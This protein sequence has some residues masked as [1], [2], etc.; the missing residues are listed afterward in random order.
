[1]KRSKRIVPAGRALRCRGGR[2]K[3][4]SRRTS[5]RK[6]TWDPSTCARLK[7]WSSRRRRTLPRT[8]VATLQV[9]RLCFMH[10]LAS[11]KRAIARRLHVRVSAPLLPSM[12][13]RNDPPAPVHR[14][15]MRTRVAR[16]ATN[17]P[18]RRSNESTGTNVACRRWEMVLN[19]RMGEGGVRSSVGAV[20]RDEE[21]RKT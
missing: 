19:E 17:A 4:S 3:A 11:S 12:G 16:I 15:W 2:R 14:R 1:M 6:R 8:T 5:T 21:L 10:R 7:R 20:N 13:R 9:R 18:R